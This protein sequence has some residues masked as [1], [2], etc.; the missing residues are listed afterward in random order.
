MQKNQENVV[1]NHIIYKPLWRD[2]EISPLDTFIY[3]LEVVNLE[4]CPTS[5]ED[6]I[7]QSKGQ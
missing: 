7:L 5:W 3:I 1:H 4:T 6:F 2:L